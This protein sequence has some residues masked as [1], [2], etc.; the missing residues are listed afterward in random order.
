[1][2]KPRIFWACCHALHDT[3]NGASLNI[4]IM[5]RQLR[6]HSFDIASLSG[7]VFSSEVGKSLFLPK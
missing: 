5:I 4:R 1:M 3:S 6:T 7:Y 2:K